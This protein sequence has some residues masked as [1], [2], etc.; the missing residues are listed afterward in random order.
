MPSHNQLIDCGGPCV[1]DTPG[2]WP[3][4]ATDELKAACEALSCS[5]PK[6][7]DDSVCL[8]DSDCVSGVCYRKPVAVA[9]TVGLATSE[10][11]DAD[12]AAA[13]LDSL[14]VEEAEVQSENE[15]LQAALAAA[16]QREKDLRLQWEA[17]VV[18]VR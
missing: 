13:G 11:T 17:E 5:M 6:C 10:N 4:A 8:A 1:T 3:N 15:G 9:Q 18:A 2:A 7:A 16:A 12:D 14:E